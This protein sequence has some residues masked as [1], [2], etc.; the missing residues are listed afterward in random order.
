M[1]M[2]RAEMYKELILLK[3]AALPKRGSRGEQVP[4]LPF[5]WGAEEV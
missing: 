3:R 1:H 2:Y 4:L 5:S